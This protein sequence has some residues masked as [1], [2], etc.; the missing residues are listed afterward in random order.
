MV[1]IALVIVV[2]LH[3][4]S[5]GK[6]REEKKN[7]RQTELCCNRWCR[8]HTQRERERV[9]K[10]SKKISNESREKTHRIE[11][12]KRRRIANMLVVWFTRVHFDSRPK[13][14][15]MILCTAQR[16]RERE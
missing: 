11:L 8:L 14:E 3:I 13:D 15:L 9:Y 6:K 12:K 16:M 7:A 1:L 10:T 2:H 5:N 4:I